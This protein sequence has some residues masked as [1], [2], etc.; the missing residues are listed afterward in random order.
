MQRLTG[1]MKGD[2]TVHG[3]FVQFFFKIKPFKNNIVLTLK[4]S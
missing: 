1:E 2:V 3:N 4:T